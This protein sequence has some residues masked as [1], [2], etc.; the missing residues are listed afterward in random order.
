MASVT[1]LVSVLKFKNLNA[2]LTDTEFDTFISRIWKI[3]GREEILKLL[4]TPF[5]KESDESPVVNEGRSNLLDTMTTTT[6]D[7]IQDRDTKSNPRNRPN[8]KNMPTC[9]V[10]TI[11]SF[12]SQRNYIKFSRT[13]RKVY[14]DCNSP[15][16]LQK[17]RL[18]RCTDYSTVPLKHFPQIK[19]L[20]FNLK[21][22]CEFKVVNAQRFGFCNQL[23]T[24]IIDGKDGT[25]ADINL[26]IND[27]SRC[28]SSIRSL[29]LKEFGGSSKLDPAAV[30]QILSKFDKLAHFKMYVAQCEAPLSS[31]PLSLV[32]PE[33]KEFLSLSSY[34]IIPVLNAWKGRID[35]LT[36]GR[37]VRDNISNYNISAVKRL[38]FLCFDIPQID[39][40]LNLSK[41]LKEISWIPN[42]G[43]DPY[44]PLKEQQV[45]NVMKRCIVDQMSLEYLHISTRGHFGSICSGIHNGLYLTKKR[46]RKQFEIALDVDVREISNADEFVCYIAK[47]INVI[48]MSNIEEWI[49]C[50]D[51][52]DGVTGQQY[53][54]WKPMKLAVTDLLRSLQTNVQLV[55]GTKMGF[56]L[57][58]GCKMKRHNMWWK[59]DGLFVYY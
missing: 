23:E 32:C 50:V 21:Q 16:R 27:S 22:I 39:S 14:V 55:K 53:F 28:F 40:L 18:E 1:P 29:T 17:L 3:V 24:M 30:I 20:A 33:I 37:S 52:H 43:T 56:V 44:P 8:I 48:G 47:I 59:K 19:C 4:C 6:S 49:I 25:I 34:S 5:L 45:E 57:G 7:I 38:C 9:L 26:L 12:L 41:S 10:G 2:R 36:I 42:G 11:A 15:N 13:N 31:H 54:D 58:N 35:T 51:G 46:Q